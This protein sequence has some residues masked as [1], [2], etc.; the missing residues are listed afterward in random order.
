MIEN[1]QWNVDDES[2]P[3]N[4][5]EELG[6]I[7]LH[8]YSYI[9]TVAVPVR[10]AYIQEERRTDYRIHERAKKRVPHCVK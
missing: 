2:C 10:P 8:I 6:L 5:D 1:A 9:R 3:E 7:H 4:E